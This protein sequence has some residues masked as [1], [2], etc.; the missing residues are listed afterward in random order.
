ME[1]FKHLVNE[2]DFSECESIEDVA[3]VV[4]DEIEDLDIP[5]GDALDAVLSELGDWSTDKVVHTLGELDD[6]DRLTTAV[7]DIIEFEEVLEGKYQWDVTDV[8]VGLMRTQ[9]TPEVTDHLNSLP[10]WS[11]YN[12]GNA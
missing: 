2:I 1:L 6:A 5:F 9:A 3:R 8:I 10:L 7:C 12:T 4:N 11:T